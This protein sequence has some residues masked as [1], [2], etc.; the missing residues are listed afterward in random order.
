MQRLIEQGLMAGAHLCTECG[1]RHPAAA[2]RLARISH[3]WGSFDG[4]LPAALRESG[5]AIEA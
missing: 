2:L 5:S 1:T 4:K 3:S